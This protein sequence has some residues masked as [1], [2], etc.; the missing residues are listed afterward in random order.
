MEIYY[1]LLEGK[2]AKNNEESKEAA[3]AYINCWVNAKNETIAKD[4]AIKY[5]NGQGWESLN[6]EEIYITCRERYLDEPDSLEC[7][8]QAINCGIG[9]IF[10]TWPINDEDDIS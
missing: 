7:F 5:I 4:K 1:L 2:P 9:A 10:Y 3:G 8:E 6:I